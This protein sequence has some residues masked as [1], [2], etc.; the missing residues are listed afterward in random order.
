LITSSW[1]KIHNQESSG[2]RLKVTIPV[3]SSATIWIPKIGSKSAILTEGGKKIYDSN[4]IV[5]NLPEAIVGVR[6]KPGYIECEVGPGSYSFE[7]EN[8]S[9]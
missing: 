4:K 7:I 6:D 8:E 9:P 2:L 3:N 5:R 1:E